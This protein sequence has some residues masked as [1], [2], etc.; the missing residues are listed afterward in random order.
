MDAPTMAATDLVACVVCSEDMRVTMWFSLTASDTVEPEVFGGATCSQCT[1]PLCDA[2][3]MALSPAT[4][5][6][7]PVC[8][9]PLSARL[10]PTIRDWRA[11]E[12]TR[13]SQ[14]QANYEA[15]YHAYRLVTEGEGADLLMSSSSDD[16]DEDDSDDDDSHDSHDS[17][18]AEAADDAADEPEAPN[19]FL[20]DPHLTIPFAMQHVIPTIQLLIVSAIPAL[21]EVEE[22]APA[23]A[24]AAAAP[25][26]RSPRN[27]L[28][29][30]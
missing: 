30:A 23:A 17:R 24:A 2:C 29:S 20:S 9:N 22:A 4:D 5:H 26:R 27:H 8:R 1:E 10:P 21:E 15:L 13:Q 19:E 18:D 11:A 12:D 28:S 16:D 6:P 7:C 25:P 3:L 14:E